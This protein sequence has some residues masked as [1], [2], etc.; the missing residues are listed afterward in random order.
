[1]FITAAG[2]VQYL[3]PSKVAPRQ[4]HW[5]AVTLSMERPWCL[6]VHD[7]S[8]KGQK[9]SQ[10][11]LV[12]WDNTLVDLLAEIPV[13]NLTGIARLD[14]RRDAGPSWSFNW[15]GALWAPAPCEAEAVGPLLLQLDN[16]PQVRNGCLLRVDDRP[17]RRLLFEAP[18]T[19]LRWG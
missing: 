16:D 13:A 11:C 14:R 19:P 7:V 12:G 5:P 10:T 17:G 4:S 2:L 1:M 18:R 9:V 8:Y 6:L 3:H 15:I